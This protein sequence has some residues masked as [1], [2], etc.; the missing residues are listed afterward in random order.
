MIDFRAVEASANVSVLSGMT[1]SIPIHIEQKPLKIIDSSR[2][3]LK[4]SAI[5]APP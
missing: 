4:P 3:K 1:N 5:N 2:V